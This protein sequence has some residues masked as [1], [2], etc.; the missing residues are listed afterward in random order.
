MHE[1]LRHA[2]SGPQDSGCANTTQATIRG[3][4]AAARPAPHTPDAAL[5]LLALMP[6]LLPPP[7]PLPPAASVPAAIALAEPSTSTRSRLGMRCCRIC[8][9]SKNTVQKQAF[10]IRALLRILHAAAWA[11]A[12]A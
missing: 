12:A 4:H 7:L 9:G 2:V 6:P 3:H 5:L 8:Y 1:I 10:T 11:S